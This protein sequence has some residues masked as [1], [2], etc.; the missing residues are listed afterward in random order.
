IFFDIPTTDP[1]YNNGTWTIRPKTALPNLTDSVN[2]SGPGA[3]QLLVFPYYQGYRCF[4]VTTTGTVTFSGLTMYEA[5]VQNAPGGGVYN[6]ST[7]TVNINNCTLTENQSKEGGAVYN[8]TTGT[9]K[10]SSSLLTRNFA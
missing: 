4:T 3:S 5:A 7:G 8:A 10:I 9:V 2:I 6:A 1:G